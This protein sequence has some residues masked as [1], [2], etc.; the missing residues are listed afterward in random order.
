MPRAGRRLAGSPPFVRG[1]LISL[2]R[3]G[4]HDSLL[5]DN[6]HPQ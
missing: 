3:S 6:A 5:R 4:M 2:L 1:Y